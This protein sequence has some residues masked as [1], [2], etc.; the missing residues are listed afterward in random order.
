M[1]QPLALLGSLLLPTLL[2][3]CFTVQLWRDVPHHEDLRTTTRTV[4]ASEAHLL[5]D[6]DGGAMWVTLSFATEESWTSTLRA[7]HPSGSLLTIFLPDAVGQ[8]VSLQIRHAAMEAL[9][10]SEWSITLVVAR[11]G[12]DEVMTVPL[13]IVRS[14]AG[15]SPPRVERLVLDEVVWTEVRRSTFI[16]PV[17]V[18]WRVGVTPLAVGADLLLAVPVG[19]VLGVIAVTDPDLLTGG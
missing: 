12:D 10:Q 7:R 8:R 15:G 17:A 18:A 16:D 2:T 5:P 6:D 14:E 1:R 13:E 11:P 4:S 19:I 9:H 3:G